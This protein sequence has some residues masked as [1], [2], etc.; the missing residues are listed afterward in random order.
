MA[1]N[2]DFNPELAEKLAANEKDALNI[3]AEV[4]KGMSRPRHRTLKSHPHLTNANENLNYD[5]KLLGVLSTIKHLEDARNNNTGLPIKAL[6]EL[7][8][9]YKKQ[10]EYMKNTKKT[11]GVPPNLRGRLEENIKAL[12]AIL[13]VI[14]RKHANWLNGGGKRRRT[15]RK[16]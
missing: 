1:F 12:K 9:N 8:R 7:T 11:K 4:M 2:E 13:K 15:R 3:E 6:S 5:P 14:A 10:L 16:N